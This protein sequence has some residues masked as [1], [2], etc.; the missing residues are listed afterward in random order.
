[1]GRSTRP[2]RTWVGEHRR[3]FYKMCDKADFQ[4]DRDSNE[5]TLGHHILYHDHK[6]N[7]KTD[8]NDSYTV[9]ILDISS[10]KVLDVNEH[11]SIYIW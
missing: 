2:L 10:P 4:Y 6:L 5:Y 7:S 8:F 3:N 11:K 1:M 9:S